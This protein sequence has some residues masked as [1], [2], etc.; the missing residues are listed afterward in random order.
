MAH[1]ESELDSYVSKYKAAHRLK[2]QVSGRESQ[3][4]ENSY[5]NQVNSFKIEII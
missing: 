3:I 1:I 5:K 4:S 2:S